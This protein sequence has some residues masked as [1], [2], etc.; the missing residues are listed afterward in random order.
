MNLIDNPPILPAHHNISNQNFT[1]KFNLKEKNKTKLL[2][3][4]K[5]LRHVVVDHRKKNSFGG[6]IKDFHRMLK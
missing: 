5:N 3:I 4:K 2:I 1:T 6:E